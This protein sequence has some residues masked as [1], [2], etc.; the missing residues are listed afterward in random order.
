MFWLEFFS[1]CFRY[2]SA[3]NDLSDLRWR[4]FLVCLPFVFAV[5]NAV[6][7]VACENANILSSTEMIGPIIHAFH[8]RPYK[9]R[10]KAT[11]LFG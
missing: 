5:V 2:G 6:D 1:I 8:L 3:M 4:T 10:K 7:T 11:I 9:Y